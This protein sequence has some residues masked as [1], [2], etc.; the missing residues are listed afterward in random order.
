MTATET[1]TTTISKA[2]LTNIKRLERVICVEDASSHPLPTPSPTAVVETFHKCNPD[3]PLLNKHEASK[4]VL[5]A[6]NRLTSKDS[7]LKELYAVNFRTSVIPQAPT[8]KQSSYK[9]GSMLGHGQFHIVYEVNDHGGA[10]GG[11]AVGNTTTHA[12]RRQQQSTKFSKYAGDRVVIKTLRPKIKDMKVRALASGAADLVK[13][14][15][16]LQAMNL[17]SNIIDLKGMS[18]AGVNGWLS[19]Q[20]DGFFLVL[21]ELTTTLKDK[22]SNGGDWKDEDMFVSERLGHDYSYGYYYYHPPTETTKP[23]PTEETTA[24]ATPKHR[25][26]ALGWL[27]GSPKHH[28]HSEEDPNLHYRSPQALKVLV[29]KQHN[30][31]CT[32]LQKCIDMADALQYMHSYRILHRDLKPANIV[33]T[34]TKSCCFFFFFFFSLIYSV[35]NHDNRH[36]IVFTSRPTFTTYVYVGLRSSSYKTNIEGI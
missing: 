20:H 33:S 28:K 26:G 21:E 4:M 32:R 23:T 2:S 35:T 17:H 1:T 15:L 13:E 12:E 5:L 36:R 22:L 9:L 16:L 29:D 27:F 25:G 19:G 30:F 34:S 14:G 11:A 18:A 6:S 10:P 31:F 3:Q 8:Q 7:G 24:G